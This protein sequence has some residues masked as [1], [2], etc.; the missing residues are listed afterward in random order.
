MAQTEISS[1]FTTE[2]GLAKVKN[3][4]AVLRVLMGELR[5]GVGVAILISVTNFIF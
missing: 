4:I 2:E 5:K 1:V 3:V